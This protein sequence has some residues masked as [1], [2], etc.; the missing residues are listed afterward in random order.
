MINNTYT[1]RVNDFL[2]YSRV[3]ATFYDIII[4]PRYSTPQ[5]SAKAPNFTIDELSSA[6]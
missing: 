4:E 1:V 3:Y 6:N 5:H 2:R